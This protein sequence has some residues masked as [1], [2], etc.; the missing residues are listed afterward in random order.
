MFIA[1]YSVII[2]ILMLHGI[3]GS[4]IQNFQPRI[5]PEYDYISINEYYFNPNASLPDIPNELKCKTDYYLLQLKGPVYNEMKKVIDSHGARICEYVPFNTFIIKMSDLTRQNIEELPFVTWLGNYEPAYKLSPLFNK[6][7]EE[8][9][10]IVVLFNNVDVNRT[11]NSLDKIDLEILDVAISDYDKVILIKTDHENL[12]KLSPIPDIRYIEPFLETVAF[13]DKAQWVTQTWQSQNRRIWHKGL[14]GNGEI[15]NSCDTGILTSHNMFRDPAYP[16][17]TWGDYPEHRKIIA[18]KQPAAS[19]SAFGDHSAA[20]WHGTHT[21][22]T[23]CGD[24]SYVAGIEDC[25]GMPTKARNYFMDI[26]TSAGGLSL[27]RNYDNLWLPP[28]NGNAG[29][30]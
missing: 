29:G 26:G 19:A 15:V 25:D 16:I 9:R 23:L 17:S 7:R 27:P 18:Y 4:G 14:C 28:Y 2:H 30:V 5:S 1:A 12:V 11:L 24:D 3:S 20:A 8:R 22:G 13:N 21:A 6:I 10:V